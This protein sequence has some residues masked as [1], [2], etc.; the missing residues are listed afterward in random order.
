MS[1][2]RTLLSRSSTILALLLISVTGKV[3]GDEAPG[4]TD[5]RIL[6]GMTVCRPS[7]TAPACEEAGLIPLSY[8]R[9][10]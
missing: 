3:S 8:R 7:P 2:L 9:R 4:V 10:T 1:H 6:V 5:D